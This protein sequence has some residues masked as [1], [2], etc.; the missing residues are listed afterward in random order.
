MEGLANILETNR[1][2]VYGEPKY[3]EQSEGIEISEIFHREESATLE[4]R[5]I[6]NADIVS[7]LSQ[8]PAAAN[9]ASKG[10]G[11]TRIVWLHHNMT[12]PPLQYEINKSSY[13]FITERFELK[14]VRQLMAS[15]NLICLPAQHQSGKESL[16]LSILGA[17]FE[18]MWTY[19]WMTYSTEVII[20]VDYTR[21]LLTPLRI[22]LES[23]KRLARHPMFM[24]FVFAIS[25]LSTVD[26]ELANLHRDF[27]QVENRTRHTPL[28]HS[29]LPAAVGSYATLS[30]MMSGCSAYAVSMEDHS[31]QLREILSCLSKYQWPQ[32]V[33]QPEWAQTMVKEV[34]EC[35]EV[36]RLRHEA[37]AR[38]LHDSSRRA[39]IQLTALF[40][41]IAQEETQLS[42]RV[43]QDSRTLASATK[44][45]STAMKTLAAVTVI[46]LPGT[47]VAALFSMPLFQWD[48]QTLGASVLSRQFWIY[49][50]VTGPLKVVTLTLWFVWMR[51]QTRRRR[52]RE[53]EDA[54][55]LYSQ[56]I[57]EPRAKLGK[58]RKRARGV[59]DEA[60]DLEER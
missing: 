48:T 46:F 4:T 16:A 40:N 31:A 3:N 23:Q 12:I 17:S 25:L 5:T 19:D 43:V 21:I 60:R 27:V 59:R 38:S 45:D 57:E 39:D 54:E 26:A 7:W 8:P 18:T 24:A 42:I 14:R 2:F 10:Y 53:L 51:W 34:N 50:A 47:F 37:Q 55:S 13:E 22:V 49:W 28:S 35:V 52:A 33:E 41:L 11:T 20:L 6:I 9:L 15:G 44:D 29:Q 30:A 56:I 58:L 32:D 36:M 1:H